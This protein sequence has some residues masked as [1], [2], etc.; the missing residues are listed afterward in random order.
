M[1]TLLVIAIRVIVILLVLRFVLR[2]MAGARTTA[3]PK[4]ARPTRMAERA[5]GTLVR[6]PQCGTYIPESRA[7]TVTGGGAALH[8]CSD[9][10]R[11]AYAAAHRGRSSHVYKTS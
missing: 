3:R 8:F 6:D 9:A 11:D 1:M 5:G 4:Q 2:L 10:C 7:I